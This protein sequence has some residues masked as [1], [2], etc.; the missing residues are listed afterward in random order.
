M[1]RKVKFNRNVESIYR[2]LGGTKN[3]WVGV[4]KARRGNESTWWNTANKRMYQQNVAIKNHYKILSSTANA[5]LCC[6]G[7]GCGDQGGVWGARQETWSWDQVRLNPVT[8][9]TFVTC[10]I[11]CDKNHFVSF[12]T[13]EVGNLRLRSGETPSVTFV[14]FITC[15]SFVSF[16][17]FVTF[18]NLKLTTL[19]P[20]SQCA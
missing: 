17:S 12:V 4:K 20:V 1:K 8:F 3:C 16:V 15:V 5:Q 14:N 10:V 19:S 13:R 9:V 6:S 11:T 2:F 18:V 7:G